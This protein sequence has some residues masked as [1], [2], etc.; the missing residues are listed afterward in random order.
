MNAAEFSDLLGQLPGDMLAAAF[1]NMSPPAADDRSEEPAEPVFPAVR[2]AEKTD[3]ISAP[4]WITAAAL[5]ACM[6]FAAGVGAFQL[7]GHHENL[8][9]QSSSA[10]SGEAGIV[11]AV[12]TE[13][14][15]PVTAETAAGSGTQTAAQT[16]TAA[17]VSVPVS[18]AAGDIPAETTAQITEPASQ[19]VTEPER[20][21]PPHTTENQ[22]Q[23]D[24]GITDWVT[25]AADTGTT[26][27]SG[28]ETT[29]ARVRIP[30]SGALLY[31]RTEPEPFAAPAEPKERTCTFRE[32][33]DADL[34]MFADAAAGFDRSAYNLICAEI[35]GAFSDAAITSVRSNGEMYRVMILFPI[36]FGSAAELHTV[37]YLLAFP[38]ETEVRAEQL[39]AVWD[40]VLGT[41]T[42][43]PEEDFR[44][45]LSDLAGSISFNP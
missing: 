19:H 20:T 11:T 3:R 15:A 40:A 6:L 13:T 31:C 43:T 30:A 24:P 26:E 27:R 10:D 17:A 22:A 1:R 33:S 8:T 39:Q 5:A 29:T 2:P 42:V 37:T 41:E 45:V 35:S 23:T 7:R 25:T 4:R 21:E 44:L 18:A 34:A 14:T 32:A 12:R 28:S 9:A 16:Q 38:K 36:S